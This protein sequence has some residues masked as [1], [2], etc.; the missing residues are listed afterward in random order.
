[1]RKKG[2][3]KEEVGAAASKSSN[4][5]G[6]DKAGESREAW[7]DT[8]EDEFSKTNPMFKQGRVANPIIKQPTEDSHTLKGE[9]LEEVT[10]V[11]EGKGGRADAGGVTTLD[12][13]DVAAEGLVQPPLEVRGVSMTAAPPPP[14][15]LPSLE[16]EAE[17]EEEVAPPQ[18]QTPSL[19]TRLSISAP[20]PPPP[21]GL[22][23]SPE[24]PLELS[25]PE[26]DD[27]LEAS[28]FQPSPP[29]TLTLRGR[30]PP[31]AAPGPSPQGVTRRGLTSQ[32]AR[33]LA[34]S[35][36]AKNPLR[37]GEMKS[38]LPH[39]KNSHSF[40]NSLPETAEEQEKE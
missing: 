18:S 1:M 24:L 3:K 21:E 9:D 13:R 19:V 35:Y 26:L 5:A 22:P 14:P 37:A 27:S 7:G 23:F 34:S 28:P 12:V 10:G 32:S 15:P 6:V 33:L 16:A 17:A 36:H 20:P 39:L 11:E 25:P 8:E 31:L 29:P 4:G 40:F 2:G 38:R 30:A